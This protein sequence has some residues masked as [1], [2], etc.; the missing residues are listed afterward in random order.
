[1]TE[2]CFRTCR[3][4]ESGFTLIELI[5]V[6]ILVGILAVAAMPRF[7]DNTFSERGFHDGV[8]AAVQ[9]ARRVA[10]AS[11]RYVCVTTT[12][13]T[14]AAANVAIAF[15]TTV[16][17]AAVAPVACGTMIP[18]PAPRPAPCAVNAVCAPNSVTL[19]TL[20]GASAIFDP[21]GRSVTAAR[22][23]Q[24]APLAI[25]MTGQPSVTIQPE[26]GWIQ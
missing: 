17:E 15:D 7:F 1:M 26:T 14:G 10:V 22:A 20:G 9:H 13:G 8:K 23:V 3:N 11:R 25:T 21:L 18:L 4:Q 16:P 6:M 24:A 12:G 2:H 5:T 19:G